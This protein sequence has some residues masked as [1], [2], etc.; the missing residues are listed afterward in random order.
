MKRTGALFV[1]T[2][3][4][5]QII[6]YNLPNGGKI[7]ALLV[8]GSNDYINY[9]HQ[10]DICHAYQILHAN[11]IPDENI[12]VMMYDD[13]A[14][15]YRN[16]RKGVLINHPDG[17]N[18]YKGVLKDYT[19]KTVNSTNFLKIL[20]GDAE[21]MK[22]IGSGR[23]INSGPN[24][25][26]FVNFADHGTSGLIAFP[27]DELYASDLLATIKK[28]A[29]N[30]RFAKLVMYVEACE[31]GSMFDKLLPEDLNVFAVTAAKPQEA[32]YSIYYD[33]YLDAYLGD[34][35]SVRW[36]E[37]TDKEKTNEE[38][39]KYQFDLVHNE[40]K[41]SHVSEYGD[42]TIGSMYVS[43][44]MGFRKRNN[45]ISASNSGLPS[46]DDAVSSRDV[47][48][49]ILEHKFEAEVDPK[50]KQEYL[51]QLHKIRKYRRHLEKVVEEILL[52]GSDKDE[53]LVQ[54][55]QYHTY[56][57]ELDDF[58]CYK[59]LVSTFS[60]SCFSISK[61]P[62][63]LS[64]LHLFA[65][66]CGHPEINEDSVVAAIKKVCSSQELIVGVH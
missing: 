39:L 25:H 32:S 4:F 20:S 66:V 42:L 44:F 45:N 24:D 30:N 6:G 12:I 28:M 3:L 10:A 59:K 65:N 2:A 26:L 54:Q 36:M 9:R 53:R 50:K 34:E 46:M 41:S 56:S 23:V 60:K 64:Q 48:I 22:G 62:H 16:P 5:T 11:G 37:D 21:G 38:K 7:W 35:F 52:L 51:Y 58:D 27:N 18:V 57:L 63:V 61:N 43:D 13:I 15:H 55:L 1:I 19:G 8:A 47:P 29:A 49:A 17:P 14:Y 33:S 31:A 40:I